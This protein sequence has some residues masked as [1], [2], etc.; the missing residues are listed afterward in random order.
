MTQI[1]GGDVLGAF[2]FGDGE[3][4]V[5]YHAPHALRILQRHFGR[6]KG[7]GVVTEHVGLVDTEMI[8][9]GDDSRGPLLD[10]RYPGCGVGEAEAGGVD[11]DEADAPGNEWLERGLELTRRL[12][13]LMQENQW[14]LADARLHESARIL[15]VNQPIQVARVTTPH[16]SIVN[17]TDGRGLFG[18]GGNTGVEERETV[19]HREGIL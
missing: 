3:W 2:G 10:L 18:S 12:G 13:R 16:D 11:R 4:A 14:P 19:C 15:E 5:Q 8:E 1:A 9:D 17:G 7:A 6:Y